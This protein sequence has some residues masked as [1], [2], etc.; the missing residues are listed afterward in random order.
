[1][2]RI[3]F[4]AL[5]F[6]KRFGNVRPYAGLGLSIDVVGRAR[7]F[8]FDDEESVDDAVFERVDERK[9]QAALLAMAGVQFQVQR[10][11]VFVQASS[12]R[13]VA[14]SAWKERTRILRRRRAIQLR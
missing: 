10:A 8:L 13:S 12:C 14:V 9:S 1:M 5:A 11:A 6:P 2:N 4:A 7:P 3:G